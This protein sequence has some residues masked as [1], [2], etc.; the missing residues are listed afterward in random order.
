MSNAP[1]INQKDAERVLVCGV[2]LPDQAVEREGPLT[3]ARGLCKASGAVVVG[4]GITQHR[5]RPSSATL[6]AAERPKRSPPPSPFTA[7]TQSLSTTTCRQP[8]CATSKRSLGAASSIA[9]S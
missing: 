8:K 3:E 1:Q 6:M 2:L 5:E 4:E 9:R 7:P